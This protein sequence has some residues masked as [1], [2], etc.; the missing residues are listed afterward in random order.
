MPAYLVMVTYLVLVLGAAASAPAIYDRLPR[1][2]SDWMFGLA[3]VGVVG[4]LVG[5]SLRR[6]DLSP[7]GIY[8]A[9]FYT[10]IIWVWLELGCRS[11]GATGLRRFGFSRQ[12]SLWQEVTWL[13]PALGIAALTWNGANQI[14]LWSF[15]L[16]WWAHLS[17]R[18]TAYAAAH[19]RTGGPLL[20]PPW[21]A[22]GLPPAQVLSA[23]F[24]VTVSITT[25]AC[26]LFACDA[27]VA[28]ATTAE[29]VTGLLLAAQAVVACAALW[30]DVVPLEVWPGRRVQAWRSMWRRRPVS[31]GAR[32]LRD[33]S[34]G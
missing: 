19:A 3:T 23:I 21:F 5:L 11:P 9:H 31:F 4:A 34:Q 26:A 14:G 22:V 10:M 29:G 30:W 20:W 16:C 27:L 13:P 2:V 8:A 28:G 18:L 6:D 1:A 17:M 12:S 25:A 7:G 15:L 32:P 24:P 33:V